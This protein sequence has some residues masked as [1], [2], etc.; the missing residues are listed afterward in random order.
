MAVGIARVSEAS[1]ALAM[2]VL[3]KECLSCHND[4][5]RKDGLSLA[6]REALMKGGDDGPVLVEGKPEESAIVTSLAPE[7]DPH[8]PPKK[9][10]GAAHAKVLADWVRAGAAWDA[11]AL[12]GESAP[13]EVAL[14][15]MPATYHPVLALAL[16]PDGKTLAAGC[17]PNVCLLEVSADGLKP[18]SR[19]S[20]HLDAVQSLAW[21]PDGQR[22]VSGAFRRALVWSAEPLAVQ[23]EVTGGLTDRISAVAALPDGATVFLADGTV[24]ERGVVRVL[25]VATGHV[26]RTWPAHDDTIFALALSPDATTL[27]TAGGDKLVKLWHAQTGAELARLEA[28]GTQAM[29]AAFSPDGA[30]LVTGGADR[31]LEVWDVKT[32]ENTIDLVPKGAPFNAVAWSATGPAIFAADDDGALLK[33]T[34]FKPHTGAQSSDTGNK[35]QLGK[36]SVPLYCLAASADASIVCAGTA[37]GHLLAWNKDGKLLTDLDLTAPSK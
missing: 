1:P 2:Q 26:E 22:L 4:E 11:A 29:A 35:R 10:L 6:S 19:A 7:A 20:A 32:K 8:M 17:G 33:F 13:R 21:L 28:H 3:K 25:N 14:A 18:K 23:R 12:S 5:K 9:Q 31:R 34:D 30:Q 37:D 15:A 27:A 24:A 16:S 36:A